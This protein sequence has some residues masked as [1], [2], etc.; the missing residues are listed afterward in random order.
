MAKELSNEEREILAQVKQALDYVKNRED[1]SRLADVFRCLRQATNLLEQVEG[2]K[3][4][5]KA[6]A[7]ARLQVGKALI[8]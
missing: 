6:V 2:L 5:K 1:L 7:K 8:S 3:E 4:I